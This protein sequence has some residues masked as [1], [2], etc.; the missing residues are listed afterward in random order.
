MDN[1][2]RLSTSD[3]S[4]IFELSQFAFQYK[5]DDEAMEKKRQE[6]DRHTIWGYMDD[7]NIAAKLHLIPLTTMINGKP[8]K[9]GG[10]S[11]VATWPQ[12]RRQGMAKKLLFHALTHMKA[13]GQTI[14]FL[15]PFSFGFY[16]QYGF[17]HTFNLKHY[18]IPVEKMAGRWQG[19]GYVHRSEF[20]IP[21]LNAIYSDYA[22]HF[23]G[24]IMRDDKWWKERAFKQVEQI[25]IAYNERNEAEGYI[26]Y[27]VKDDEVV[28]KELAYQTMNGWQLLLEFIANHDSMAKTI[29]MT[30]PENDQLAILAHEP[31]FSQRI[32]PYFMARIVDVQAFLKEYPFETAVTANESVTIIVDDP[33]FPENEGLY[34]LTHKGEKVIVARDKSDRH[35]QSAIFCT[36]QQLTVM[37][38]GYKR[39]LELFELGLIDGD[40]AEIRK[41]GEWISKQATYYT[42]ADFF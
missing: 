42:L 37:L 8:F 32:E 21:T 14:T 28:V 19:K 2:K 6:A 27:V 23:T 29:K 35:S 24:T 34:R 33:F 25:A 12:Y 9:M 40:M 16:R 13:A 3:Y 22:K 17:E 10:I 18:T 39:P 11:S 4:E 36:I 41:F 26:H 20:D 38:L 1:I 15:H 31:D 5:L 7:G 30:V